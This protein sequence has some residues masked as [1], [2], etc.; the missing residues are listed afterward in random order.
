MFQRKFQRNIRFLT[1][2]FSLVL[3]M[4]AIGWSQVSTSSITG[5]VQDSSGAFIAGARVSAVNEATGVSYET[6][7]T[8]S[9]DYT[10]SAVPPGNYTINITHHNFRTLTST[11]NVL[12]V[13]VPLVVN[14]ALQVGTA[15]E[16][17][18]V[19][20]T[21]ERVETTNAMIS[22]V[23]TQKET[24]TLPLNGRN[25]LA[26]ITLEP[27]LTQRT[28]A[29]A[30]SGTHVFGS[31]DRSHNVT[32]DGIDSNESSVPNPQSNLY[33]LNPDN[34]QEFRVVTHNATSEFGRNSGAN[35]AIAT[36][37]G[38]NDIH[39]DVFYFNRNTAFNADEWFNKYNRIVN[40]NQ[41]SRKADLKLNQ[42][43]TDVGGPIIKDKT[44]W[45]FSFQQN[46]IQ[47]AI[48][49]A[50]SYGTPLVY[51]P[52]MRSGI[53]RYFVPDPK[54]PLTINGTTIKGNSTLL[55]DRN[56]NP[57]VPPCGTSVTVNC[58]AQVNIPQLD[59]TTNTAAHPTGPGIIDPT[60]ANLVSKLP[61]PNDYGSAGDGLNFAGFSWTPPS[62]FAGPNVL[63]RLDHI[64]NPHN[65]VFGRYMWADFDTTQGDFLNARPSV[66]PGFP[67][68]GTVYRNTHNL[69]LSYR[70]VFNDNLVNEVTTGYSLF[71]FRFNLR[72]NQTSVNPP[73]YAQDCFGGA[74]FLTVNMPYCNTPH[75]Q[76][77]VTNIQ[78]IDNLSWVRGSHNYKFGANI[79]NYRH[80]DER[81]SPGGFNQPATIKFGDSLRSA[82]FTTPAGM[83]STDVSAFN[84]VATEI[85]GIPGRVDQAYVANIPG[86]FYASTLSR[87]HT[88]ARQFDLYAQDEWKFRPNLTLNYGVRWEFNPPATDAAHE[89][90]VPDRFITDFSRGNVNFVKSDK[91]WKRMNA[92]AFAPRIGL[93]YSPG[94]SAKI[95]I[96]A[97]Y[98]IAFDTLSTFQVTAIGGKVP[99]TVKQCRPT[100]NGN[101]TPGCASISLPG[102]GRLT[103]LLGAINPFTL[104]SPSTPPST[105]F[106]PVPAA[107]TNAPDVGAFDPNLKL[108]TV[109]EWSL[110]IQREL[111]LQTIVQI[112]YVGKHG[113]HLYRA[114][115]I[116]QLRTDQPGFLDSFLIART[117]VRNGCNADGTFSNGTAGCGQSPTLLRQL[118]GCGSTAC[119]TQN[120]NG[121]TFKN[122]FLQNGLGESARRI[123]TT[124][125]TQMLAAGFPAN[126]FRPN[127]QFS[128]IFFQDS[129]GSSIY[130]GA[131]IQLRRQFSK[132]LGF[133]ASYTFSKSIDD[134]SVDPTGA[135][136]G[137]G[138]SSQNSRTPT[139]V[140]NFKLDR[141]VSDFDNTHIVSVNLIYDLP[142]GQGK[143][144]AG[145]SGWLNQVIGGWTFTTIHDWQSGEPFTV[146][147]GIRTANG[148]KV[149]RAAL[150]G[151]M[152]S[153]D[154]KFVPGVEGPVAFDA[155]GLDSTT[156][157]RTINKTSSQL[158]I[159][160]PGQYGL[161]RNAFRGPGFWNTDM[162]LLK[163]FKI[164][165][166]IQTQFRAEFFN[167]FNHVNFE[168]PRNA[169]T[170]SGALFAN[171][172][173]SQVFGQ[174]CC[175]TA[176]LPSSATVIALGE[177]NRVIQ[178]G[179]KV[180]F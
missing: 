98:G 119:T 100:V 152:P 150:V 164:T 130:H 18:Q 38:T 134:M 41:F 122:Q 124:F 36:K 174:T 11:H 20:A 136:S 72:E 128:G 143:R 88:I 15:S 116:N 135:S 159:P 121:S 67:P 9:G 34:T 65:N 158:C 149:S 82:G 33:R 5:T 109:H 31:R 77:V 171:T 75:T 101:S 69:A 162:A 52:M 104:P 81:G 176:A 114:Y 59:A 50:Q 179:L 168:N 66:Y 85:L 39:G 173:T 13:G 92:N 29:G 146:N 74:S 94:N 64:F 7:T 115:D 53:F 30:G 14:G 54:N 57:I 138:L 166:R 37:S 46:A 93:A 118:V 55:V 87:L 151:P 42:Y 16:V 141:A 145:A 40:G 170:S 113:S 91:W 97:G 180:S 68:E 142:F 175:T 26:L 103:Q 70:H 117:N 172:L 2:S 112:G 51:T 132:D 131:F 140:R 169:S 137:G 58:I 86:D 106:S 153:T 163:N 120:L 154:L 22:D 160:E 123:D 35:V 23:V 73:P 48:P 129:Q 157:C 127:P 96:R 95:V 25:P 28:T 24:V 62:H 165:E 43:G 161:G 108:P 111:P 125:F 8:G 110:S 133:G 12:Q 3:L 139:D 27:G 99:G 79:R 155:S 102:G 4:T 21:Q 156:N 147:S 167:V 47:Q 32:I 63:G 78:F 80:N 90:F 71:N 105:Q 45:F 89:L 1:L 49:I 178:L 107:F 83:S 76:R 60:I 10:I 61:L 6:S 84:N 177:P 148:F 144:F 19:E 126:Y 44:F 17:I 56:G